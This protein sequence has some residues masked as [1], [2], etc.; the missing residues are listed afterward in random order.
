MERGQ[1]DSKTQG[2]GRT[3][4]KQYLL[5]LKRLPYLGAHRSWIEDLHV[6][7]SLNMSPKELEDILEPLFLTEEL[8]KLMVSRGG[9]VGFL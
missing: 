9:R 6:I 8:W 5:E 7:K 1:R 2:L 3:G 4:V